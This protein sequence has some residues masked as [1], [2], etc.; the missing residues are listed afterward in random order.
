[1]LIL[2]V[3]HSVHFKSKVCVCVCS[4]C[5][6]LCA[7]LYPKTSTM[8][9]EENYLLFDIQCMWRNSNWIIH[10]EL[11]Y[12][13]WRQAP[14]VKIKSWHEW[15]WSTFRLTRTNKYDNASFTIMV[16]VTSYIVVTGLCQ[17]FGFG[18]QFRKKD[19][20]ET[21]LFLCKSFK[22]TDYICTA[23]RKNF[24]IIELIYHAKIQF[25]FCVQMHLLYA[26]CVQWWQ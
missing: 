10:N 20:A 18:L 21:H 6:C 25:F 2:H 13:I 26:K 14:T 12:Y 9:R 24:S 17:P 7:W 16:G 19:L 1:M 22:L 5:S 4:H 11:I 23:C 8:N 15:M 3:R